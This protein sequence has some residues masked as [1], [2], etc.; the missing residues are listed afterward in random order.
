[1]RDMLV[2][3]NFIDWREDGEGPNFIRSGE[4]VNEFT[5]DETGVNVV[6]EDGMVSVICPRSNGSHTLITIPPVRVDSM[7]P[8]IRRDGQWVV[9]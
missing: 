5:I 4:L 9:A 3:V 2:Q 7:L 8:V 6:S 1:M